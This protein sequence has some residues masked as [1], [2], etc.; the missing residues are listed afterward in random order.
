[1]LIPNYVRCRQFRRLTRIRLHFAIYFL[2]LRGEAIKRLHGATYEA[3]RT[4][5]VPEPLS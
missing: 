5:G 2:P 1:V 4:L 3:A